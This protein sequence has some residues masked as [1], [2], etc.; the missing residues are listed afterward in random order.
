VYKRQDKL[1]G[2]SKARAIAFAPAQSTTHHAVLLSGIRGS[3][4]LKVALFSIEDE[5]G[6]PIDSVHAVLAPS[7]SAQSAAS[8]YVVDSELMDHWCGELERL[9]FDRAPIIPELAVLGDRPVIISLDKRLLVNCGRKRYG[10]DIALPDDILLALCSEDGVVFPVHGEDAASRLKVAP[11]GP[12]AGH[13]AVE[14]LNLHQSH[15]G[16]NIRTRHYLPSSRSRLFSPEQWRLPAALAGATAVLAM[17]LLGAE[18]YIMR[19]E[20][21]KMES[22]ARTRFA[23]IYS[24]GLGGRDIHHAVRTA[25][26]SARG[27]GAGGF[28]QTSAALFTAIAGMTDARIVSIDFDAATGAYRAEI[29]LSRSGDEAQLQQSLNALGLQVRTVRT[30]QDSAGAYFEV[31]IERLA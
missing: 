17:I 28:R 21:Q 10:L 12:T 4:R 31:I 5:L 20:V 27:G 18:T 19:N 24:V 11:A 22:D 6:Q 8:L 2:G 23:A 1:P 15:P 30:R 29:M 26:H 14:L 9:G 16:I 7:S 13:P 3:E 25:Y